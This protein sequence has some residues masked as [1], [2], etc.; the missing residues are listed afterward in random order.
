MCVHALHECLDLNASSA[1]IPWSV[2]A[3]FG[4]DQF[5]ELAIKFP[6]TISNANAAFAVTPPL[7]MLAKCPM[8]EA[9][10]GAL[11]VSAGPIFS[12]PRGQPF[13]E[14]VDSPGAENVMWMTNH[15]WWCGETWKAAEPF[16]RTTPR[17][18][19]LTTQCAPA[20]LANRHAAELLR[21]LADAR[22]STLHGSYGGHRKSTVA[23]PASPT[24]MRGK[25]MQSMVPLT[26]VLAAGTQ[27]HTFGRIDDIIKPVCCQVIRLAPW[28]QALPRLTMQD[29]SVM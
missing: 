9:P 24:S 18:L 10:A 22:N 20:T 11:R 1:T 19:E 8:G 3:L 15:T 28:A 21:T 2:Q 5:V 16:T 29:M 23:A 13:D 14:P 4:W 26:A 17:A 7:G 6:S 27:L 12:G 25:R